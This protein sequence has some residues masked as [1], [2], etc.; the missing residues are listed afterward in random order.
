MDYTTSLDNVVHGATGRRMHSDSIAVPTVW[1][2]NDANMVIWSMMEVLEAAG[3][4]GQPFNPDDSASYTRFRDALK[5]TIQTM[6]GNASSLKVVGQPKV[7]DFSYAGADVIL[8][9]NTSA[10]NLDLPATTSF[11]AGYGMRFYNASGFP[12]TVRTVG[13]DRFSAGAGSVASIA[14]GAGDTLH[15]SSLGKSNW[16]LVGGSAALP[17]SSL[18]ASS[19]YFQMSPSGLIRQWGAVT[20]NAAGVATVTFPIAFPNQMLG[21]LATVN[22]VLTTGLVSTYNYSKT[23]MSIGIQSYQTSAGASAAVTYEAWGN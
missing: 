17:W 7:L 1:S 23:G 3:I 16:E 18:F 12:V 21:A 14:I 11:P 2:G 9:G 22:A 20:T 8:Y 19:P 6:L 10:F 15:I 5:K 13:T 4:A